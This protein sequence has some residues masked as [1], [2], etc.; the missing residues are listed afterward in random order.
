MPGWVALWAIVMVAGAGTSAAP[1]ASAS[2]VRLTPTLASVSPDPLSARLVSQTLTISGTNLQS[3]TGL[4]M[5]PP[6][7]SSTF[8]AGSSLQ[9]VTPTSFQVTLLLNAGGVYT[10]R[11]TNGAN[12]QS[13]VLSV[14]VPTSAPVFV[15]E[16]VHLTE[17][18]AGL[19]GQSIAD[20]ATVR[21]L[22]GRW[23]TFFTGA[24][25]IH[26]AVSPDG[27]AMT[28]EPGIRLD[29]S[30]PGGLG[31]QALAA[32]LKVLRLSDGRIRAYFYS[33]DGMHSSVSSDDGQTFTLESGVRLLPSAIG[34]TYVSGGS[35]VPTSDGRWRMYFGGLA[36][37]VLS[38]TSSDLL[39]WSVDPGVRE[40][41]GTT[42]SRPSDHP[43]AIRNADGSVSVFYFHNNAASGEPGGIYVATSADGLTFTSEE[44]TGIELGNDPDAV[45]ADGVV[46]LYY[47]FGGESDGTISSARLSGSLALALAFTDDPLV[48]GTSPIRAVHIT[49]L[50]QAIDSLRGR[51]GIPVFDWTDPTIVPGGQLVRAVHVTEMRAALNSVYTT[52]GR[53]LPTYSALAAGSPI[54]TAQ[55]AEIRANI[56]SVW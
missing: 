21:L 28:I 36:R 18:S 45:L 10:F 52:L 6:T 3:L 41:P 15:P 23:R 43:S 14:L 22:D 4:L 1:A 48:P 5:T 9:A 42:L 55:L 19:P 39:T 44:F 29:P 35:V 54:T 17:I 26:S 46:R 37:T 11:V 7:G 27:L 16:G 2:R 34:D 53:T 38:A 20:S 40:G 51:Y 25:K 47:N 49:E 31:P 50:R 8:V 13:N 56:R 12:E 33:L 32:A 30:E 24:T